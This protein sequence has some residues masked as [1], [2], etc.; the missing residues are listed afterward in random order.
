[1]EELCQVVKS[2][3]G[4]FHL[5]VTMYR[6]VETDQHPRGGFIHLKMYVQDVW[7]ILYSFCREGL[8]AHDMPHHVLWLPSRSAQG[9]KAGT[10]KRMSCEQRLS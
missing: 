1:M 7:E 10:L 9:R 4:V 6:P 8:V 3:G 2:K 5:T